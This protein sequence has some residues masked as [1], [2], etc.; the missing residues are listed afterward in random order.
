MATTEAIT[1]G[2]LCKA[3]RYSCTSEPTITRACWCR[4]CQYIGAGSNTVNVFFKSADFTITGETT[5]YVC[6][7]D[8]GTVMHRRFCPK[9]G[10][11]VTGQGEARPHMISVRAGTLDYPE[12]AKP[13]M[14]IWLKQ[15]P[16]WACFDADLPQFDGQAP[17][18][19]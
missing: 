7:A 4:L 12:I 18:T 1:G 17:L 5:D 6:V 11:P 15:A 2:C 8:S 16:S 14:T 9:C 13:A 10:T 3:V 19:A